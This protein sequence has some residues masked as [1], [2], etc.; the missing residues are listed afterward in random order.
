M[1]I[2]FPPCTHLEVIDEI[3]ADR[4]NELTGLFMRVCVDDK[5]SGKLKGGTGCSGVMAVTATSV[6]A[7]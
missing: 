4:L 1:I 5:S 6:L 2:A 7:C 3:I